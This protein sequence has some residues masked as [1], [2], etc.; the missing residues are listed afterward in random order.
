MTS[1]VSF[2]KN[3]INIEFLKTTL[4]V[5]TYLN[6]IFFNDFN[7]FTNSKFT[8]RYIIFY[9]Y[10]YKRICLIATTTYL[11]MCLDTGKNISV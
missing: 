11:A 9:N 10:D 5:I 4:N 1:H 6:V 2:K 3:E 7:F 8:L